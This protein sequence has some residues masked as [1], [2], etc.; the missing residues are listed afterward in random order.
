MFK[1]F[2]LE[3]YDVYFEKM[4]VIPCK[5]QNFPID[6]LQI[7][8]NKLNY[9]V[10]IKWPGSNVIKHRWLPVMFG[11]RVDLHMRKNLKDFNCM[12][13][14]FLLE[15]EFKFLP[16]L[17]VNNNSK[18]GVVRDTLVSIIIRII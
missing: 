3:M 1:Q 10:C 14:V 8:Q 15:G 9:T 11:T 17:I 13:G 4:C 6:I 18:L 2:I 7:V 16:N 12:A 5:C